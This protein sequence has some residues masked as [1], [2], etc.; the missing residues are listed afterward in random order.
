MKKKTKKLILE[1]LDFWPMT[2][3]VPIMII[4]ILTANIW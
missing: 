3:V 2:I 4:L 1:L